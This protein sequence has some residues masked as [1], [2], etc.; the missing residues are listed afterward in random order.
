LL[1][2]HFGKAST[3]THTIVSIAHELGRKVL[4][5]LLLLPLSLLF[6]Q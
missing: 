5:P 1:G 2:N 3:C 4:F 6:H